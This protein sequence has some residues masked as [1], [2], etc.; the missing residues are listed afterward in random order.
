MLK[1]KESLI[2]YGASGH[3]KVVID[4]VEKQGL[5]QIVFIIDDNPE[6][7][8]KLFFS[9]PVLGGKDEL[10]KN[11]DSYNKIL[12]AIGKN[13]IRCSVAQWLIK[14]GY[15]LASAIH[16]SAQIG[17]DVSVGG[18]S[19]IMANAVINSATTIGENVIVNTG[20]SIDHDCEIH[21]GVHIAPGTTICGSVRVGELTFVGAGSTVI[22]NITLGK[23]VFVGA[24]T[25]VYKN[26][27]DSQK[28]VG[29][30]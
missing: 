11:S 15:E 24:G 10:L 30:R 1:N 6:L 14:H 25:T 13:R 21:D 3:A 28:I 5:Y 12:I 17:R 4:L 8:G 29:L 22:Q 9:Y 20:A 16:P 2:I 23:E 18:G 27:E 19:V 26:V 7:K